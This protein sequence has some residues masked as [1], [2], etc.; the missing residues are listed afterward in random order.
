MWGAQSCAIEPPFYAKRSLAGSDP[1]TV[2][3]AYR[4]I[5]PARTPPT[6]RLLAYAPAG[7]ICRPYYYLM[8]GVAIEFWRLRSPL[9]QSR[10]CRWIGRNSAVWPI[11]AL[12]DTL[13][14][15]SVKFV[16]L[17]KKLLAL[18]ETTAKETIGRG[19]TPCIYR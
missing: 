4:L 9:Q 14:Y 18:Q 12:A 1:T 3:P 11:L 19:T 15:F 8:L 2:W 6:A 13:R 7:P 10:P 16:V 17:Q 5:P